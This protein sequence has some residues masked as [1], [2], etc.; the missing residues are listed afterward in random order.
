MADYFS[1]G[2]WPHG[3]F[4]AAFWG[5]DTSGGGPVYA[6]GA[7][8]FSASAALV[9]VASGGAVVEP[10][11]PVRQGAGGGGRRKRFVPRPAPV[12]LPVYAD[13][14]MVVRAGAGMAARASGTINGSVTMTAGAV[15]MASPD[16]VLRVDWTAH[17][18]AFWL[19]AA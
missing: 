18:N 15:L 13:G 16:A 6:D 17:D 2:Y 7:V 8:V 19:M 14:A 4:P 3:Y 9:A 5:G 1:N 11:Q 12:R 10:P